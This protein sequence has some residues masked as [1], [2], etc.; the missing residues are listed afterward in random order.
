MENR[1]VDCEICQE[2]C[3]WNQKHIETPLNTS[4]GVSFQQKMENWEKLFYLPDLI[5]L[6]ESRYQKTIGR[7]NTD[8]PYELFHRNVLIANGKISNL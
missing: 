1:V 7:L 2:A 4:L 8:I 3:P 5:E 6:S